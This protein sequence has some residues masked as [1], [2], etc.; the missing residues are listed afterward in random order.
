MCSTSCALLQHGDQNCNTE[1]RNSN[2]CGERP[3]VP[4][5]LMLHGNNSAT[6]KSKIARNLY[7]HFALHVLYCHIGI[8]SATPKSEIV[9]P[10]IGNC[11]S[12]RE[13]PLVP[14]HVLW[15]S[16][17]SNSATLKME[18]GRD[19]DFSHSAACA[20]LSHWDRKCNTEIKNW[21]LWNRKFRFP[22]KEATCST[23]RALLPH[24]EQ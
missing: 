11:N 20:L 9:N 5:H 13:R 1:I 16:M 23:A 2:F 24:R 19:S 21:K 17:G 18:I 7:F 14:L 8:K 4:L 12:R 15:C 3:L 6:L 10:K 22:Q